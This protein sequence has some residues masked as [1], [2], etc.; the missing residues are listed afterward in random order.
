MSLKTE[1]DT[2]AARQS[3][4]DGTPGK[5]LSRWYKTGIVGA[6]RRTAILALAPAAILMIVFLFVPALDGIRTSLSS[7]SGFGPLDFVGFSN[8]TDALTNPLF[9]QSMLRSVIFTV[10]ST[11]GVVVIALILAAA[12][13]GRTPGYR[14]YRVVWFIPGVAPIAAGAVFWTSAFQPGQGVVNVVL[15]ALG[16]GS[17]HA[18]LASATLSI[19]PT[20]FVTIWSSAGFAFLLFLGAMEQIPVSVYE[21]ARIDGAGTFRMFFSM[22]L[23][24]IRPVL[25]IVTLLQ[26]IWHFNGFT[27]LYAM[28][29]GGPGYATTTLPVLVYREA[30]Q[31]L[32]YGPASAMAI[33]GGLVLLGIGI[34]SVR[35]NR[36]RQEV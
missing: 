18:W 12:V 4:T 29:K 20:I 19:Y 11:V 31:Q 22:T 17:N 16:L 28:T 24:L 13:S 36:S 2:S 23:P 35:L 32:D 9:W 10:I 26:I 33:L 27:V 15:G 14:F 8:Y 25:V 21:A 34:A 5:R 6:K 1:L 30:F 7:W 3:R